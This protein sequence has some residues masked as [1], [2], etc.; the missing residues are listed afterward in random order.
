MC[1]IVHLMMK[2][3]VCKTHMGHDTQDK[4]CAQPASHTTP[5]VRCYDKGF[6]RCDA[7]FM[8]LPLE[9]RAVQMA[10]RNTEAELTN[11]G[12]K[13][14]LLVRTPQDEEEYKDIHEPKRF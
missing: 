10:T 7:C 4:A 12:E 6:D 14:W 13:I 2:C 5:P 11:V 9:R 1:Y 3:F 8:R